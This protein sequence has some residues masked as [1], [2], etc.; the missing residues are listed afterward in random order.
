MPAVEQP[1]GFLLGYL[2][3]ARKPRTEVRGDDY[4]LPKC[5]K[6][7]IILLNKVVNLGDGCQGSINFL[8]TFGID[9]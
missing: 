3:I 2:L 8:L 9:A 1:A 6:S 4:R 5:K 7:Y